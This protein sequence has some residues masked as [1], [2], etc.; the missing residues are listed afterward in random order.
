M[1]RPKK[2]KGKGK[3][4]KIYL[5]E[6]LWVIQNQPK[7]IHVKEGH[8]EEDDYCNTREEDYCNTEKLSNG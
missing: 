6:Q 5:K 1:K 8:A 4:I 7:G 2:E 3:S